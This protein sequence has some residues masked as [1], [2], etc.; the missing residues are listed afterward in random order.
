MLVAT[1]W[2]HHAGKRQG[3]LPNALRVMAGR[4]RTS[5]IGARYAEGN[6]AASRC[7]LDARSCHAITLHLS[8]RAV[9]GGPTGHESSCPACPGLTG[10]SSLHRR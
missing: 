4:R 9:T 6:I 5:G 7:Y 3:H 1:R 8:H 10:G 2:S